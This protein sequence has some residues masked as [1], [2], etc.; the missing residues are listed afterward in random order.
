M[1][2]PFFF[3]VRSEDPVNNWGL[4]MIWCGAIKDYFFSPPGRWLIQ[5]MR[6]VCHSDLKLKEGIVVRLKTS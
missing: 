6:S 5:G 3:P 1:K 2:S 4:I